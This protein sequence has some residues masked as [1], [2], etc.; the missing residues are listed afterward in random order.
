MDGF[1]VRLGGFAFRAFGIGMNS[2]WKW[3][4]I[5][6]LA[7]PLSLWLGSVI[8]RSLP[9]NE[10]ISPRDPRPGQAVKLHVGPRVRSLN[11]WW[12]GSDIAFA[13]ETPSAFA[14][15][16]AAASDQWTH[17][18]SESEKDSPLEFQPYVAVQLAPDRALA[19]RTL[20]GAVSV[21]GSYPSPVDKGSFV[22][23]T[24]RWTASFNITV[25]RFSEW[26]LSKIAGT[27]FFAGLASGI[28]AFVLGSWTL[29]GRI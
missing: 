26:V 14:G 27:L 11:G 23:Q 4:G 24:D 8:G 17:H 10:G 15:T 1:S 22:T 9:V 16:A 20:T 12:K 18:V 19:G 6:L 7:C 13:P 21:S 25:Y 2:R 29:T 3:P 28:L 5:L